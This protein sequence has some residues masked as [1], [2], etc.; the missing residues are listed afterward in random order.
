MVFIYENVNNGYVGD[1]VIIDEDVNQMYKYSLINNGG[2]KFIFKNNKIYFFVFV[3][4]DYE[5]KFE[6]I[7]GVRSI[8]NGILR[9]SFDKMFIVQVSLVCLV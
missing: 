9:L 1:F 7:I 3:N 5:R 2:W 8:D 6:Y 4:L